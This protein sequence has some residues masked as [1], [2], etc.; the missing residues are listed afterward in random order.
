MFLGCGISASNVSFDIQTQEISSRFEEIS[1]ADLKN[2]EKLRKIIEEKTR[3]RMRQELIKTHENNMSKFSHKLNKDEKM[4][5]AEEIE[6]IEIEMNKSNLEIEKKVSEKIEEIKNEKN[7]T[8][9]EKLRKIMTEIYKIT[10]SYHGSFRIDNSGDF[11]HFSKKMTDDLKDKDI[12]EPIKNL[13][14]LIDVVK[15]LPSSTCEEIKELKLALLS[16]VGRTTSPK[17]TIDSP[18]EV[19][20]DILLRYNYSLL[21]DRVGKILTKKKLPQN[22]RNFIIL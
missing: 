14:D 17:K 20:A 18:Q 2:E 8:K 6:R 4:N 16:E 21:M 15:K 13:N 12:N 19:I 22:I 10:G 9:E 3:E 1:E 5:L 11:D 7:V